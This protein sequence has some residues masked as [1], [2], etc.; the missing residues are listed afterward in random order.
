VGKGELNPRLGFSF[1]KGEGRFLTNASNE[2]IDV[3]SCEN[4]QTNLDGPGFWLC[5]KRLLSGSIRLVA[6]T[7]AASEPFD[8]SL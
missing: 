5:Q 6:Q 1:G 8:D 2:E 7:V 3:N 4:K